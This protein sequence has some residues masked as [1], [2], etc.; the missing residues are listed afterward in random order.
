MTMPSEILNPGSVGIGFGILTM[1]QN[2]GITLG[3]PL[4]GYLLISTGSMELTS[5]G[6]AMFALLG[7]LVACTLKTR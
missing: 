6:I 5:M 3:S 2:I 7:S 4:A 1:C